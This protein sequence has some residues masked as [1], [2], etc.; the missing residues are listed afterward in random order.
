MFIFFSINCEVGQI[1]VAQRLGERHTT[2]D[3][4]LFFLNFHNFGAPYPREFICDSSRALL[5]AAVLT[6]SRFRNIEEYAE[7]I[8]DNPT[9]A[10]Y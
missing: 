2:K 5:N 8:K 6:Y 10:F 7:G 3:V 9:V 1:T 4:M